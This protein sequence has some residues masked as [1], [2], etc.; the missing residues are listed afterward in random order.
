MCYKKKF[1]KLITNDRLI[2]TKNKLAYYESLS[3]G[4]INLI[5]HFMQH[6]NRL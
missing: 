2:K 3:L 6:D 4:V 1:Y 5:I